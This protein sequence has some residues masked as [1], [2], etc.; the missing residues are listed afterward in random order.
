M[1][2]LNTVSTQNPC[3]DV[4]L[5]NKKIARIAFSIVIMFL[6]ASPLAPLT[7]AQANTENRLG[8]TLRIA[9]LRDPISFNGILNF[10]STTAYFNADMFDRLLTY[11]KNYNL[12]GDLAQSWQS[13]PDGKTWTF[14]LYQNVTWHDGVKFTSADVKWH[15]LNLLNNTSLM[16]SFLNAAN[17]TSIDTPDDYTVIFHFQN[18]AHAD[19]IFALAQ[20]DSYILPKH[21][22]EG[23]DFQNNPANLKPIGT[24]PFKFVDY[25][26]DDHVT[27]EANPNYFRGRPYL[28]KLIWLIIPQQQTSEL[29]FQN[30][31]V[32]NIHE[33]LG[34]PFAD[35]SSWQ[36]TQGIT[37]DTF[38]YYTT[39]RITFNFRP[40]AVAK[41]PWLGD[42]RVRQAMWY[43]IDRQ[44]IIN[45]VL[46]GITAPTDTAISNVI[47]PY[48]NP[49]TVKY[50]YDPDKAN[51]LLDAAGYPK[52]PDGWRFHTP[53]VSYQTGGPFAEVIKQ[54]LAKV[55]I[56]VDLRLIENTTFFS[57]YEINPD[58]FGDD[59]PMGIQTFGTGPDP[60]TIF[61]WIHSRPGGLGGENSGWYSNATVDHLLEEA[62]NSND[63]NLR[64][65]DY[66]QVQDIL[67][68]QVPMIFL[69]NNWKTEVW[70][71]TFAGFRESERPIGWYANH[72]L[73]WWTQGTPQA[74]TTVGPPTTESM[75][76]QTTQTT[77]V[78][79]T[80]TGGLDMTTIASIVVVIVVIAGAAVYLSRRR[81]ASE[82]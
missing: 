11:D 70:R 5:D 6:M 57:L 10:W 45:T 17:L 76:T 8:G 82:K 28:D 14:H 24:G 78:T 31:Q 35:I 36:Q 2:V 69:W 7:F 62:Q 39:W 53:L 1:E 68:K 75:A 29:A 63:F 4:N 61:D 32:D 48:Y 65:N 21:I 60:S 59:I 44:S 38:Q 54:Y 64:R 58:G 9:Y 52:G 33:T 41:F 46:Y 3:C 27:M 49:N 47:A 56:D 13:T 43:A 30:S 12:I 26:K 34:L 22:F 80:P 42:V 37:V 20:A 71:N 50:P 19:N 25:V 81:K 72:R 73:V 16:R 18:V 74:T 67:A 77:Q 79:Q 40:K 55:G 23:T 51:Q 15:Y 66:F